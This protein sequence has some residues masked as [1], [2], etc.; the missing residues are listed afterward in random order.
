MIKKIKNNKKII[1]FKNKN[2]KETKQILISLN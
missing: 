2:Q 1:K